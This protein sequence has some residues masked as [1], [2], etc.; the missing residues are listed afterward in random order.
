MLSKY[1]QEGERIKLEIDVIPPFLSFWGRVY[2]IEKKLFIVEISG[3]YIQ[4]EPRKVK[5]TL[6]TEQKVCIFD[7]IIHGS[8]KNMLIIEMPNNNK[9]QVLQRRRYIRVPIDIGVQCF[10]L[11]INDQKIE[12]NKYISAIAKDISGGGVL[13]NSS[14]SL[15]IGTVVVFEINLD[16]ISLILTAKV[17]RNEENQTDA[18][19]DMGCEFIGL[20]DSNLMQLINFASKQQL[21]NKRR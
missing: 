21:K 3:Q 1:L 7:T 19:R 20:D 12:T 15:P 16:G 17:L 5:C 13:I 9:V 14:V 11:G 4:K 8:Q 6:P 2:K 10:I 18:T